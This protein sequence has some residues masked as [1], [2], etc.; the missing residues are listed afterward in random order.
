MG[1]STSY[2]QF[3]PV[4]R[5]AEIVTSRWTPVLLRE[6]LAGS[7]KFNDLRNGVPQMSPSL[8]SKRLNELEE[9]G[10]VDKIKQK[11][12]RGHEYRITKSGKELAPI[13]MTLGVW[14]QKFIMEEFS[15]HELDPTLLMWDIQRRLD[16]S[17]FPKN[18]RFVAS[19]YLVGAPAERRMWWLVVNDQDVELCVHN[20]GYDEDLE[21]EACLR[22]LTEVWMGQTSID[23]AKKNNHLVMKGDSKY[24]KN[25]QKWFLLS[26]FAENHPNF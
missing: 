21:I 2:G 26:P 23:Q 4:A 25:F 11:T 3:C 20:P 13:V 5:A 12:G 10:I 1:N 14:G 9:A 8:L 16:T 6:L 7:Q 24:I 15:E 19:F 22:G 17:Y 18:G